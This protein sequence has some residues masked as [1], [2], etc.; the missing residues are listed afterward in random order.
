MIAILDDVLKRN[1]EQARKA[2]TLSLALSFDKGLDAL[3]Q[4]VLENARAFL[5]TRIA[6]LLLLSDDQSYL[7]LEAAAGLPEELIQ[8]ERVPFGAGISG[9][10]AKIGRPISIPD[11][12]KYLLSRQE[13]C[14]NYYHGAFASAPLLVGNRIIGVL[15]MSA[16][17]DSG[18]FT[19]TDLYQLSLLAG[20]AGM[21][22]EN[23]R[24][25]EQAQ[26]EIT[27]RKQVEDELQKYR[28]H[29]EELVEQRTADL[30]IANEQLQREITERKRVEQIQAV[31]FSISQATAKSRN[32]KE[33][34]KNICEQLGTLIDT[35]NCYTALY[36][37]EKD[38]YSFPFY[39]D[40][41]D[42]LEPY[43]TE[44][45]PK[46]L[47]DYVRRTGEPLLVDEEVF[48]E[49]IQKG[50]V[51]LVGTRASIWL[52]IPLKT[53]QEVIG[54][55]AVQSY[56]KKS[57]YSAK[58]LELMTFV[59]ENIA[60]AIERKLAEDALR[61]S[62]EKYRHLVE[63]AND[64][65]ALIQ[66]GLLEYINPRMTEI[67]G[68]AQNELI[69]QPFT[70]Y[71]HPDELST[72]I[73][74]Y[75]QRMAG[76]NMPVIYET[77]I[78]SKDGRALNVEVNAGLIT[79]RG[80]PA[81]LVFVRDITS[82]KQT[83]K[84]LRKY[85]EHLEELV[86]E[87]TIQLETAQQELEQEF[88]AHKKEEQERRKL[89]EQL[90][91][92]EKMEAIGQL[93]GGIAHDLNNHLSGVL[94]YAGL[95]RDRLEDETF[96]R[97][98]ETIVKA[99]KNA[100]GLVTQLLAFARKGKFQTIEVDTHKVIA[101]VVTLLEHSIDRRIRIIRHLQAD[102]SKIMGEPNQ[103]QSALLNIA[104]NARD[105][106]PAGGSLTFSTEVVKLREKDCRYHLYK[107][108]PGRYLQISII[109]TGIG[110][111]KETLKRIFEPFFSTKEKDKGTGLG[112]AVVYGTVRS[113]KG[114]I[115]VYSEQKKG[116]IFKIY[117]PLT[118]TKTGTKKPGT[119]DPGKIMATGHI[120]IVDDEAI[121]RELTAEILQEFGYKVTTCKDG[122]EA[123]EY[124][125]KSWQQIDLVMLDM[126]MPKLNGR[127][128]FIALCKIN[129]KVRIIILSGYSITGEAQELLDQGALFFLQKPFQATQIRRII[130]KVLQ[131]H[132]KIGE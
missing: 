93:T 68:Y 3:Y 31:L 132:S 62:E 73:E 70:T 54:V 76:E 90:H 49:L 96:K 120:L 24:L 42:K 17:E 4:S 126:F 33:L 72:I 102:P 89:E 107:I 23:T 7:K 131:N 12:E 59:S 125:K 53:K 78:I 10:V 51:R 81:D 75:K 57:L 103:L 95:L 80:K 123:V 128:T 26:Q 15:N 61:E 44:P 60:F 115:N 85:R 32:L 22:I 34:L 35:S 88:N 130:K 104:L 18:T 106:M 8:Q 117:L 63:R 116:T 84:E 46:S 64:G 113:H 36:D 77:V 92:S 105:A 16:R 41:Y 55:V 112:L 101:E 21:A 114:F 94:G 27:E 43:A 127:D 67:F 79:Y 87:R 48:Q 98:A 119:A 65:I 5:G 122:V 82:R 39:V 30:T 25:Y 99:S 58:D 45:L 37:K 2:R 108:T 14:E 111:D 121:V 97:Y 28:E 19:T 50:E 11:V 13:S 110:M 124:Y 9:R 91:Q 118:N 129:P 47:T 69:G 71:I 38:R 52:G 109:D 56:N 86:K 6:S 29:L 1:I 20:Q 83:E 100:A 74:R 66:D 40:E